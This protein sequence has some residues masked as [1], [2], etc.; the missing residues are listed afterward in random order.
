MPA[1][2]IEEKVARLEGRVDEHSKFFESLSVKLTLL[3]DKGDRNRE[4]LGEKVDRTKEEL[5][6]KIDRLD[7][8][9]ETVRRDMYTNFRWIVGIQITTW[10][11]VLLAIL[12]K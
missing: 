6:K 10:I 8:K 1:L 4:E 3:E 11:T 12:F 7:P 2:E 9:I 5:E